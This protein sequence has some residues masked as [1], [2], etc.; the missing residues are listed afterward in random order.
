MRLRNTEKI[1][2]VMGQISNQSYQAT[3]WTIRKRSNNPWKQL[4]EQSNLAILI[5]IKVKLP[6]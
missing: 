1:K 3:F 2:S 5:K 4:R 6:A